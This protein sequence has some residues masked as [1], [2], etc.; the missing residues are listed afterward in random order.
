MWAGPA[1]RATSTRWWTSRAT[2]CPRGRRASC[3]S[4]ARGVFTGYYLNPEENAKAFDADGFFKTGDVASIEEEGYVTITGRIKE[5]INRG[6][7]SISATV[8]ERLI[9]RHPDVAASW[10]S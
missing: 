3:W 8:I 4:R 6:G 1:A 9:D 10:R 7:E 5:M 2:S